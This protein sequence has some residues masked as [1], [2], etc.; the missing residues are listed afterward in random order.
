MTTQARVAYVLKVYPRFSQ[1]FVVNEILAH[2]AA[3][4]SLDIFSL[5]L[6]DDVRFHES[7]ARVRSPVHQIRCP[8]S[9]APAFLGQ[10]HATAKLLPKVWQVVADNPD[11][12]ASDMHQAMVLALAVHEKGIR[13]LHAHFGTIATTTSRLAAR[14]TGI[15]YSFTAHAKDI[16]HE[17]VD[18]QVLHNKLADAAAVVTVSDYNL[19]YLRSN[20]A[21]AADRVVHIDNGLPLQEF[22]FNEPRDRNPLI[23]AVGR[24]V[25]KKGF[26]ELIRACGLLKA[27]GQRF[28]CEIAGGGVLKDELSGLIQNLGLA[29]CVFLLGPRPQGEIREKLH[30]AAILAAP[31]VVAADQDRDGLPTILLEAMA[32]GTPCISTDVTGIPEVLREGETGL[33]VPQRDIEG[34]AGACERLLDDPDLGIQLARNARRQIEE[35]FDIVNNAGRIRQMIAT[36]IG[37][38]EI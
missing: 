17:S 4:L 22:P 18:K 5:R 23:L 27:K 33:S 24:L 20:Y 12:I 6:S 8:S 25:E 1:T 32:M 16:Y 28:R 34:L 26:A 9:K 2:E 3:G 7:L 35:K 31:C 29:D 30:V 14:M 13:H 36:V 15:T 38:R 10:L 19:K 21:T 11:V 37:G